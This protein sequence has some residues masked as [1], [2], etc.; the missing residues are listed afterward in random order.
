M[1][2][3]KDLTGE[4]FN[5]LSVIKRA[6]NTK[7]GQAQWLCRCT[8]GNTRIVRGNALRTGRTTDCGHIG[9]E[10]LLARNYKHGHAKRKG[11]SPT[12]ESWRGMLERCNNTSNKYYH[13]YGGAGIKV[14]EDWMMF[15]NF[16][17]DMGERPEGFT[18]ERIDT[19]GDYTKENCKW[20]SR[21]EQALNRKWQWN[22]PR[23]TKSQ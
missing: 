16:L 17:D 18:I 9:K 12:Y 11:F 2:L 1:S 23:A 5:S 21:S 10:R 3:L 22:D 15:S 14:C 6:D 8:C 7:D 13:N 19:L 20:A 4:T